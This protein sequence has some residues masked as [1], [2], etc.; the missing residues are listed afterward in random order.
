MIT[1]LFQ[2]VHIRLLQVLSCNADIRGPLSSD[3]NS[4]SPTDGR[5]A[6]GATFVGPLPIRLFLDAHLLLCSF[7]SFSYQNMWGLGPRVFVVRDGS[8]YL[9]SCKMLLL[10]YII[11][12]SVFLGCMHLYVCN[13]LCI[14]GTFENS[15]SG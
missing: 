8:F 1:L 7:F 3:T 11:I 2:V 4:C 14:V 6:L 10:L 5:C 13:V 12:C 15:N 9:Y